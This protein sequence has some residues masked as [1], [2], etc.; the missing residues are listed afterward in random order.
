MG[1]ALSEALVL[2]PNFE[3][4]DEMQ[5]VIDRSG[6]KKNLF[7]T[8]KFGIVSQL[9]SHTIELRYFLIASSSSST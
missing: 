4:T 7:I 2:P 8:G 9:V 1:E 3:I 5:C 6:E